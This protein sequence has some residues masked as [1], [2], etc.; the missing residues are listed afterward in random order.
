M[1]YQDHWLKGRA[2]KKGY[3]GCAERYALI[4]AFCERFDG[5]PFSVC[6][7]GA[8][9][10]YFGLRLVEDF[11]ACTVVA[12]EHDHF[13]ERQSLVRANRAWRLVLLNHRVR[14]TDLHVLAT[15]AHFDVVLALSVLHHTGGELHDW[16]VALRHLGENVILELARDDSARASA[17][18]GHQLPDDAIVLGEA[19]T[20]IKG[21]A[22]RPIAWIAGMAR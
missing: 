20:H 21:S 15:C 1:T 3:R 17:R 2:V 7:I 5:R 13:P 6:D 9:M 11:P 22:T 16:L 14:M 8:N 19:P 18:R 12:F 10:S 4:R